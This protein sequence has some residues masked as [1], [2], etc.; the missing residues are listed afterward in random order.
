M[1]RVNFLSYFLTRDENFGPNIN[2]TSLTR[3]QGRIMRFHILKAKI[4]ENVSY[5][6]KSLDPSLAPRSSELTR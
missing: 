2:V 6:N 3:V 1:R 4:R 5:V